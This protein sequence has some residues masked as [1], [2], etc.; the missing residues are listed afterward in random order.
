M[1]YLKIVKWINQQ[2]RK[3]NA[4]GV[5][6]GLSGGIDSAVVGVLCKI[7]YP[8]DTLAL[9]LPCYS[10]KQDIEDAKYIAEKFKIRYEIINLE[11]P[12]DT[13][14][15]ILPE[16]NK[17]SYANLKPRLR[18][19]TLYYFANC[20]NYLVV[21]TGNKSEISM[22]YFTKYGD[23]GVDILPLGNLLKTEVKVLAK[24]LKIPMRIINK[25]PSAGLWKGQTDEDEM[26]ITYNE[27]D[28]ILSGME[29]RNL[30]GLNEN[31]IYKVKMQI[32]KTK[33]K[34]SMPRI[35]KGR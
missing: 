13:L 29:K 26:G 20:Y 32:L 3:S 22:G 23:G 16:G 9:I 27:L 12:Y 2:V 6:F 18:M 5:V 28:K 15:K 1:D 35:Y 14:V 30:D 7:A 31:K 17:L 24:Q 25:T 21:G 34:R 19:L 11:K 10:L 4:K 8:E 33:H